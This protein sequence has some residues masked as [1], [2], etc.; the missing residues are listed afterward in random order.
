[1][2]LLYQGVCS[3]GLATFATPFFLVFFFPFL[4]VVVRG[5]IVGYGCVG[6]LV[7]VEEVQCDVWRFEG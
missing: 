3:R 5:A 2:Y 1:M 6:L 4:V 7:E